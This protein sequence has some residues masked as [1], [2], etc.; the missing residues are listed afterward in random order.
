MKK[1]NREENDNGS[2]KAN[3]V[4][5]NE[6]ESYSM[7]IYQRNI[8]INVKTVIVVAWRNGQ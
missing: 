8:M 1:A 7:S 5:S 2:M 6:S 3:G 4:M